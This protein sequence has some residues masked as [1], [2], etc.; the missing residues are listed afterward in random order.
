VRCIKMFYPGYIH[1]P[2]LKFLQR[3]LLNPEI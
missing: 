2:H 3:Y 1:H